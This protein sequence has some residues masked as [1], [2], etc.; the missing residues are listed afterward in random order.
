MFL[1]CRIKIKLT[2]G[3]FN[4][5]TPYSGLISIASKGFLLTS[6]ITARGGRK[7]DSRALKGT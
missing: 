1:T 6:E 4:P 2:R 3:V 7:S 5:K